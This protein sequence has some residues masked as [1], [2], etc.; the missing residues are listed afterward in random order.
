MTAMADSSS[1]T[2]VVGLAVA[3]VGVAFAALLMMRRAAEEDARQT[4]TRLLGC[5]AVE[6]KWVAL[7]DTHHWRVEGCGMHGMLVCE[8][9]S[10][11][12]YIAPDER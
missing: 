11:G 4:A 2:W 5:N 10:P 9:D 3:L 8:P 7:G 1:R 6:V 12:C